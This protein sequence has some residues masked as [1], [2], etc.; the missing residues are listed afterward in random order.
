MVEES[1]IPGG[2]LGRVP[3]CSL[4]SQPAGG[5]RNARSVPRS[6]DDPRNRNI[7]FNAVSLKQ[8][9]AEGEALALTSF[10]CSLIELLPSR[11]QVTFTQPPLRHTVKVCSSRNVSLFGRRQSP[12]K[13]GQTVTICSVLGLL[14][15]MQ[16][17]NHCVHESPF[18][19]VCG[20]G[21]PAGISMSFS[22]SLLKFSLICHALVI[23][24]GHF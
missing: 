13:S 5:S 17:K 18:C 11:P 19:L 16:E 9:M 7:W 2:C 20:G 4:H 10:P 14:S 24:W 3:R 21:G 23:S 6:N 15:Q 8:V 22:V 1:P 12:P